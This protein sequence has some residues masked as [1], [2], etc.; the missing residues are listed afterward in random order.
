MLVR[1]ADPSSAP[2]SAV[3]ESA[4][5]AKAVIPAKDSVM[6]PCS[7]AVLLTRPLVDSALRKL[8]QT[9]AVLQLTY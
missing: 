7:D 2:V 3:T 4:L 5:I 9:G 8:L 6:I 1:W